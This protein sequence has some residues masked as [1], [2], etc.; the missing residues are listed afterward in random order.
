[1]QKTP[2]EQLPKM[3]EKKYSIYFVSRASEELAASS[4]RKEQ[5]HEVGEASDYAG[6]VWEG[7]KR[8]NQ[9]ALIKEHVKSTK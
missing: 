9:T 4:A 8:L 2:R 5:D 6:K 3:A 7:A 1:M